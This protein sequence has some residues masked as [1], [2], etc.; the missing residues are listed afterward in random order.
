MYNAF[1]LPHFNYG[2]TIWNDVCSTHINKLSKLQRRAA[3]VITGE[4]Y[5]VCSTQILENLG[6]TSIDEALRKRETLMTFKALTGRSPNYLTE[7]FTTCEN[8]NFH[9]RS[10]NTKF[11][12]LKPK[13]NFLKRSFSYRAA[14][15]WNELPCEITDSFRNL[16]VLSLKWRM[17]NAVI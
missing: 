13:T 4:T 15:A 7:L 5:A 9:L 3:H 14:K 10:T 1:V 12:L 11:S 17:K 16:S 6:W 8:D 2:S